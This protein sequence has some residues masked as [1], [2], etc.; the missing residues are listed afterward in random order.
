MAIRFACKDRGGWILA[1]GC[2]Y[3]I[4]SILSA[5]QLA[6]KR[7]FRPFL[8]LIYERARKLHA[9]MLFAPQPSENNYV[10]L[11]EKL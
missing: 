10:K 7:P 6:L 4:S 5:S 8:C 9:I 3:Q 11:E 1:Q 2:L